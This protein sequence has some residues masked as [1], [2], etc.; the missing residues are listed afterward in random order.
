MV[1]TFTTT[2]AVTINVVSE[3]SSG[4]VYTLQHYVITFVRDLW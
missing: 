2:Y 4:E 1:L 3:S